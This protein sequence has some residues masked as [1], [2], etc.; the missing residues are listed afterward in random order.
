MMGNSPVVIDGFHEG[1]IGKVETEKLWSNWRL[2][3][4]SVSDAQAKTLR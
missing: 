3:F 4:F 2:P 1:A